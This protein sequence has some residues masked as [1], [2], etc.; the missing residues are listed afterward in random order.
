MMTTIANVFSSA[1]TISESIATD[2]DIMTRG[3]KAALANLDALIECFK[4]YTDYDFAGYDK[5]IEELRGRFKPARDILSATQVFM[6]AKDWTK[7]CVNPGEREKLLNQGFLKVANRVA[8]TGAQCFEAWSYV[9]KMFIHRFDQRAWIWC[10]MPILGIAKNSLYLISALFGGVNAR[11]QC[12]EFN[13]RIVFNENQRLAWE[14]DAVD[15]DAELDRCKEEFRRLVNDTR[16]LK[17]RLP[18]SAE[19]G[20]I[21]ENFEENDPIID[22]RANDR[23]ADKDQREL[24]KIICAI[25]DHGNDGVPELR[26]RLPLVFSDKVKNLEIERGKA[27]VTMYAETCKFIGISLYMGTNILL[28]FYLPYFFWLDHTIVKLAKT[29][30][31]ALGYDISFYKSIYS[32]LFPQVRNAVLPLADLSV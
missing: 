14:N 27:R 16:V 30:F 29:G 25:R 26:A 18:G 17:V 13:R 1:A 24:A 28:H 12:I 32:K 2:R 9:D 5:C 11:S 15:V 4:S 20:L 7:L 31:T 6:Q 23:N 19:P 22:N 21:P 3:V 10:K 8:T